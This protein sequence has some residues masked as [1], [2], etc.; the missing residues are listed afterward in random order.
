[1][2]YTALFIDLDDT[3][4][5]NTSGLW[6]AIRE[7]MTLF[8]HERLGLSPEVTPELRRSYVDNYGTTLRGL[9]IHYQ[10]DPWEFLAYVHDLPL[11]VYLQPDPY[12]P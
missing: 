8:M 2:P 3:I 11:E 4:Y 9:Q 12:L 6:G 5:P 10:V 7:R 1:M